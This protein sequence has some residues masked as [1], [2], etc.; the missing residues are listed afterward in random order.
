[1]VACW[2]FKSSV[3]FF[4]N[5]FFAS[6]AFLSLF[7]LPCPAAE[8][9]ATTTNSVTFTNASDILDLPRREADKA[10]PVKLQGVLTCWNPRSSLCFVQ[11]GSAGIY[12]YCQNFWEQARVGDQVEVRGVTSSGKFSPI[13]HWANVRK[14]GPGVLPPAK[15]VAIE[16]LIFGREDNQWVQIEGVIRKT[17]NEYEHYILE[18][19]AGSSRL[20]VWVMDLSKTNA[21]VVIDAKVTVRGVVCTSYNAKNQL[22]GFH[23]LCPDFSQIDVL[24]PA[25]PDP[26]AAPTAITKDLLSYSRRS[27]AEHRVHLQ[28]TVL[29]HRPGSELVLHDAAGGIRVLS[30]SKSLLNP[31]DL[32]DVSGFPSP[33]GY[34][35]ILEEAIYRKVG[36]SELPRPVSITAT[37]ALAGTFDNELVTLAGV[38]LAKETSGTNQVL[39]MEAD[40]RVFRAYLDESPAA[41]AHEDLVPGS[42]IRLTGVCRVNGTA[43][44]APNTFSILAPKGADLTVLELPSWWKITRLAWITGV[45]AAL[46]LVCLLAAYVMRYKVA[47]RTEAIRKREQAL[48]ERYRDLFENAN[49]IIY[50]HNLEGRMTSINRAGEQILG[51]PLGELLALNIGDLI[52]PE[53]KGIVR[54]Q[55]DRKLAGLPR[56]NYEVEA[57]TKQRRRVVLEVC[58]RLQYE[59]GQLVGIQGIARDITA[60]KEAEAALRESEQQLRQSLEQRERLGRDLHDGIIQSIYAVGLNLEDCRRTIVQDPKHVEQ[61]L[62][63]ILANLNDVI[64]DVRNFILGLESDALRGQEFKVAL[65]SLILTMGETNLSRFSMQVDQTAAEG[66]TPEEATQLLHIAREAMS[67]S[68]RHSEAQRTILSL[69]RDDGHLKFEVQDDGVGFNPQ[70]TSR[71]GHGLRNMAARAANLGAAFRVISQ[72]GEGTRIMLDIP[73]KKHHQSV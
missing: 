27:R 31:G 48:E 10:F 66:L 60:R 46:A 58:S 19:V 18:V 56:T 42:K 32:I 35:P 15:L 61:R 3:N 45:I 17:R 33:T 38:L 47:Q 72:I 59:D 62:R 69:S 9:A 1:M 26:F 40:K 70:S 67:N 16:Q 29:L 51:Y 2:S 36:V 34:T 14:L 57:Q 37:Q 25:D 49:D 20:P 7:A 11:D 53:H 73:K 13:V 65:K 5:W 63:G 41:E 44:Q 39:V 54:R 24:E 71:Q 21:Q 30:S 22:N 4:Q 28:G 23:L 8:N 68:I 55:M 12:V 50:S 64:R 43:N 52:A 6:M